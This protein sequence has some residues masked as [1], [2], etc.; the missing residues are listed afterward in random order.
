MQ[1]KLNQKPLGNKYH[2]NLIF[3]CINYG[4]EIWFQG[5]ASN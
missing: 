3:G 2:V 5:S 1:N 4:N